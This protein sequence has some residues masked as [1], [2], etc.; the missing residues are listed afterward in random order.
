MRACGGGEGGACPLPHRAAAVHGP[1][2]MRRAAWLLHGSLAGGTCARARPRMHAAGTHTR[3]ACWP[4]SHAAPLLRLAC[5]AVAAGFPALLATCEWRRRE[6]ALAW[7]P[8]VRL[9]LWVQQLRRPRLPPPAPASCRG[10]ACRP[11]EAA[12]ACPSWASPSCSRPCTV[13]EGPTQLR[14]L[15][16]AAHL[17][18]PA[19]RRKAPL[20]ETP[21]LGPT[22]TPCT[23]AS[24]GAAGA[25]A[26]QR[27]GWAGWM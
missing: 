21:S 22:A 12:A 10:W 17:P 6:K 7:G 20:P 8:R 27:R 15:A 11:A 3:A 16:A 19:C 13:H 26:R 24:M 9:A 25:W 1:L 2:P 23:A 5:R 18:P 14:L 4:C